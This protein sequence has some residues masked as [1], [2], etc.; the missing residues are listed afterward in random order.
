MKWVEL[1]QKLIAA[2]R[3]HPPSD[4]VPCFFEKRIMARLT[5]KAGLD[6]WAF[7][8]RAL[9]RGALSCAAIALLLGA[10]SFFTPASGSANGD[11]SQDFENAV[12]AAI[13]Q[14]MDYVW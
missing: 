11:F 8:A 6:Q 9:W 5:A 2:A 7:W 1:E 4:Q 3:T 13:D 12:F 14:E 10:W